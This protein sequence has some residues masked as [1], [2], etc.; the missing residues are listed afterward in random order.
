LPGGIFLVRELGIDQ[1]DVDPAQKFEDAFADRV[2]GL[3]Q[4]AF[5]VPAEEEGPA[6]GCDAVGGVASR[7]AGGPGFDQGRS[8]RER[9]SGLE[10]MHREVGGQFVEGHR[11]IAAVHDSAQH[12][13]NAVASDVFGRVNMD[14]ATGGED[15]REHGKPQQVVPVRVGEAQGEGGRAR[16]H[17][18][19]AQGADARTR[20]DDDAVPCV[21]E[22]F[23]AGRVAAVA[24]RFWRCHGDGAPGAADDDFHVRSCLAETVR[25]ARFVQKREMCVKLWD[26]V[27]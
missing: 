21:R 13:A 26:E 15:G 16:G 27:G 8:D 5:V 18:L 10:V 1:G 17:E 22:H 25:T 24:M 4:V 3:T 6:V 23:D 2:A 7:M 20:V 14:A 12:V 19:V 11:K 9:F